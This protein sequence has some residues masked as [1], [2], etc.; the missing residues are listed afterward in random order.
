MTTSSGNAMS[1]NRL[2]RS[3]VG[4]VLSRISGSKLSA[5][6]PLRS[7]VQFNRNMYKSVW[8]SVSAQ[9]DD[10]KM[11]VSGYIDEETYRLTGEG[12]RNMLRQFVGINADDV[13]LEIGAGVG[14]VGAFLAPICKEWIGTDVSENMLAHARRRL[15]E[16]NNVR[17]IPINGF[18]LSNIASAS[19]NV[20]YCTVVFMHL[21]EW[22]RYSYVREGFRVLKPGG[23]LLVDNIDLTSDEGWEL[24]LGH[25]AIAPSERP[26]QISKTSTPQELETYFMRAGYENIEQTKAGLWLFTYGRKPVVAQP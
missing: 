17:T 24:F 5:K 22:E 6:K 19:V 20:V 13:V 9:E 11:A 16:F 8:N 23:R 3:T 21:E 10:A 7:N 2:I 4:T 12:T 25:C 18:D 14:R 1:L 15:A 26:P